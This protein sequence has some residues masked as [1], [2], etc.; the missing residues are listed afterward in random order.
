MGGVIKTFHGVAFCFSAEFEGARRRINPLE[1]DAY[2]GREENLVRDVF[3][4]VGE[5]GRREGNTRSR[6]LLD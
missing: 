1:E 3:D 6:G 4:Q 5:G 2:V